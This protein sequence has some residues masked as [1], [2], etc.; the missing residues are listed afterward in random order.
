MTVAKEFGKNF[1]GIRAGN[2][3]SN[4]G[5]ETTKGCA[6]VDVEKEALQKPMLRSPAPFFEEEL[7]FAHIHQINQLQVY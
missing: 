3:K 5:S 4:L 7:M 1:I 6:G 2:L